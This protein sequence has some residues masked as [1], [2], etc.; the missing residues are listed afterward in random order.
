MQQAVLDHSMWNASPG[1]GDSLSQ[2]RNVA[3]RGELPGYAYLTANERQ[4]LRDIYQGAKYEF[5]RT[6]LPGSTLEQYLGE[7]AGLPRQIDPLKG[8][9]KS[10]SSLPSKETLYAGQGS[11]I[12]QVPWSRIDPRANF[13]DVVPAELK[14]F[15]RD[16]DALATIQLRKSSL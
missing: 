6:K 15:G 14:T 12:G 7:R 9:L 8:V 3:A 13:T 11:P 2:I 1:L 16:A 10:E 4:F 5:D